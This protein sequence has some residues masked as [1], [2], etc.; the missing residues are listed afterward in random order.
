MLGLLLHSACK[1]EISLPNAIV[2]YY[3]RFL[4]SLA[5]RYKQ[6]VL[7]V[8]DLVE[9]CAFCEVCGKEMRGLTMLLQTTINWKCRLKK[10]YLCLASPDKSQAVGHHGL[11]QHDTSGGNPVFYRTGDLK[12]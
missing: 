11:G 10:M 3:H 7:Q 4:S 9:Y 12:V 1:P 6:D 5:E 2:E 8:R